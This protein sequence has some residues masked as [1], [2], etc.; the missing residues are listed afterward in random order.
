M[1]DET[2]KNEKTN[3]SR[4]EVRKA[5]WHGMN[6]ISQNSRLAIYLRDGLACAYCSA[7]I[8]SGTILSLDHIKAH[9]V[10]GTNEAT[11]LITC[12]KRCNESKG[13]RTLPDFAKAVAGYLNHGVDPKEIVKHVRA[14][15]KRDLKPFK[16]QARAM[17]ESRGSV[18]KV[19]ANL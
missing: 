11:N 18:A 13:K 16:A 15:V 14:C 12:C 9:N 2:T 5:K 3:I 17:I 10:G 19:L 6:W 4:Y 7:N 1:S 8:E